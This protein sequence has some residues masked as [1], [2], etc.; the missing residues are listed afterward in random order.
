MQKGP[1]HCSVSIYKAKRSKHSLNALYLSLSIWVLTLTRFEPWLPQARRTSL[2]EN[3]L[4]LR[5]RLLNKHPGRPGSFTENLGSHR[6][7]ISRSGSR[8]GSS[9][10]SSSWLSDSSPSP[11]S[12]SSLST[13]TSLLLPPPP[14][15]PPPLPPKASRSHSLSLS[16][17]SFPLGSQIFLFIF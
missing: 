10:C 6:N 14:P 13:L 17:F 2:E 3:L 5:L 9:H 11:F 16:L 15:P 12:S 1:L 4:L 7:P 8:T